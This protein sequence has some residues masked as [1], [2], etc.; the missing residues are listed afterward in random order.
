MW[1]DPIYYFDPIKSKHN[2]N[3]TIIHLCSQSNWIQ[4]LWNLNVSIKSL[5]SFGL[6]QCNIGHTF[7]RSA[8]V[9]NISCVIVETQKQ[10]YPSI[11]SPSE[12]GGSFCW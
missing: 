7:L 2:F 5:I 4:T 11:L 8:E 10:T 3:N 9:K 1:S 12:C 6:S